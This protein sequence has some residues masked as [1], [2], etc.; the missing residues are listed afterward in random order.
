MSKIAPI[1]R[2]EFLQLRRDPRLIPILFFAPIIQLLLLGYAANLDVRDIPTVVCDRDG[3]TSSRDFLAEFLNSGYFTPTASVQDIREIDRYLD[4]GR[5]AM[6]IVVEPGFGAKLAGG[7]P[8]SVQL[9][10]DGTESQSAA[11]GIG[12]AGRIGSRFIQKVMGETFARMKG[13]GFRPIRIDP[14][15]RVWYNP[16]LRSRNFMIP[17][18]LGLVLM[19]ITMMLTSMAIVREKE[20]GTLEQLVVTPIRPIELII[21]KLLP[22]VLIGVIDFALVVGVVVLW[23]RIPI[24]GSLGLLFGLSLVFMVA[25]LGLG[26]F[27]STVSRN[28]QQAMMTAVFFMLPMMLLSGFVF[29][30]E[31]MPRFFQ[32]ITFVVPLRYFFVIIRSIFLKGV[33]LEALWDEALAL[34]VFGAAILALSVMRFKKRVD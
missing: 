22:F 24:Q 32:W 3:T 8:A 11:I 5:A 18:V 29:P 7:V 17:G 19:V 14:Q 25:M 2:K 16:A 33:G 34:L 23:F 15:V 21:G 12:Y 28:Q 10:V 26:L 27:I 20:A 13:R 9:I 6:S 1:I 30:I 4:E 31:N